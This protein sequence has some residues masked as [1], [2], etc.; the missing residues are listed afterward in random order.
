MGDICN[1]LVC[2]VQ[3]FYLPANFASFVQILGKRS[4]SYLS[5]SFSMRCYP[6]RRPHYAV[7]LLG[8]EYH[9]IPIEEGGY[10]VGTSDYQALWRE[11][12]TFV[13]PDGTPGYKPVYCMVCIQAS[14]YLYCR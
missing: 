7:P 8:R 12:E 3:E 14:L 10:T 11:M 1:L 13:N 9:Q 6:P 4:L 5:F 2:Y